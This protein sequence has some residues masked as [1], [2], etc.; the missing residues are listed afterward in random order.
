M[1][2]TFDKA[3]KEGGENIQILY[4]THLGPLY[5]TTNT[6]VEGGEVLYLGSKNLG[7]KFLK[8]DNGFII[9]HG[10]SHTAEGYITLNTQNRTDK[11]IFNPGACKDGHYGILD[12][13]KDKN[14]KDNI[15]II[16]ISIKRITSK[17]LKEEEINS[18]LQSIDNVVKN[19]YNLDGI[20][21]IKKLLVFIYSNKE[22]INKNQKIYFIESLTS[23][24]NETKKLRQEEI[25]ICNENLKQIFLETNIDIINI[26]NKDKDNKEKSDK[27]SMNNCASATNIDN[28]SYQNNDLSK[29]LINKNNNNNI[30]NNMKFSNKDE[31]SDKN[32]NSIN[33]IESLNSNSDKNQNIDKYSNSDIKKDNSIIVNDRLDTVSINENSNNEKDK[34]K[35][36]Q[37]GENKISY[38]IKA[39]NLSIFSRYSESSKHQIL[40]LEKEKQE[41]EERNKKNEEEKKKL[42]ENNKNLEAKLKEY[43]QLF[44]K[45]NISN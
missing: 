4:L 5:T 2:Q 41:Y 40:K 16:K 8:E 25:I 23:L 10:H 9:V 24:L 39:S 36:D 42:E 20:L 38:N 29:K 17:I 27:N 26:E 6:I 44:K 33:K 31:I 13:K 32:E 45:L 15:N 11:H 37:Y 22:K 21:E 1:N 19:K 7:E 18:Y 30:S 28:F 12:I 43:E 34:N 35:S 3:I 14:I